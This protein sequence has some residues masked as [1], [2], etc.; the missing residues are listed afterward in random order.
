MSLCP[1]SLL[2]LEGEL[3]GWREDYIYTELMFY[4]KKINGFEDPWAIVEHLVNQKVIDK[5]VLNEKVIDEDIVYIK[6]VDE[7]IDT[8]LGMLLKKD[9]NH[10]KIYIGEEY[11]LSE[12]EI[13]GRSGE[14]TN[15]FGISIEP[16][17]DLAKILISKEYSHLS[18]K[19]P[20]SVYFATF[21]VRCMSFFKDK[22][23][24][25]YLNEAFKALG[26][27]DQAYLTETPIEDLKKIKA[28]QKFR[29]SDA[30]KKAHEFRH[31]SWKPVVMRLYNDTDWAIE[32]KKDNRHQRAEWI[33][34]ELQKIV[35]KEGMFPGYGGVTVR[36]VTDFLRKEY[37]WPD[38]KK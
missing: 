35:D 21:G 14:A 17:A 26:Y 7:N 9:E 23:N 29:R 1:V 37:P 19:V 18:L 6:D 30:A 16:L 33:A 36:W 38:S 8:L 34:T 22:G 25:I 20:S 28:E 5:D 32:L 13:I 15:F 12:N 31:E 24:G 2:F 11:C 4:L 10:Q 27:A 3:D